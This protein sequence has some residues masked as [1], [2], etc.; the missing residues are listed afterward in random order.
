MRTLF[1]L[2]LIV[3]AISVVSAQENPRNAPDL[4]VFQALAGKRTESGILIPEMNGQPL[5]GKAI[6]VGQPVLG[7][8]WFQIDGSANYGPA[9]WVYR[10]MFRFIERDGQ[11]KLFATYYDTIGQ[12]IDYEGRWVEE[13]QQAQLV[14]K[15]A[16][17]GTARYQ[18]TLGEEGSV[19]IESVVSDAD[20]NASAI[21]SARNVA[22]VE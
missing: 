2:L 12:K 6:S 17:G 19:R 5:Q 1:H 7:G 13:D 10:W 14:G 9:K 20:G 15:L 11:N 8:L 18:L 21:Y 22:A 4:P 16:N 3:S